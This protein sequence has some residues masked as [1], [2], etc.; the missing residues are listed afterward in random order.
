M[1]IALDKPVST[2]HELNS[3]GDTNIT[4]DPE[5]DT[6]VGAAR[7]HFARLRGEGYLAYKVGP[8]NESS[9][10]HI[11]EFDPAAYRIVMTRQLQGG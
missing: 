3:T 2:R 9:A 4:W 5:N 1:T 8:G 6:E 11:R 10:E 7:E